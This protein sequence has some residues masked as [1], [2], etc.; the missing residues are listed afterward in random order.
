MTDTLTAPALPEENTALEAPEQGDA[1]GTQPARKRTARRKVSA[2][3]NDQKAARRTVRSTVRTVLTL[4]SADG[5]DRALL[6]ELLGC[7]DDEVELTA[8]ILVPGATNAS[9]VLEDLERIT[10]VTGDDR[11][12]EAGALDENRAKALWAAL[13]HLNLLTGELPASQVLAA[14]K[15]TRALDEADHEYLGARLDAVR[16]LLTV[17]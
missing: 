4:Q 9:Q 2:A 7:E 15:I 3:A 10:D 17:A 11:L 6:A 16:T 1:A 14:L 8:H 5:E 12:V 13:A